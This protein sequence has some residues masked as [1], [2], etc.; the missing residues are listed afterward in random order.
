MQRRRSRFATGASRCAR[1]P[2]DL[3]HTHTMSVANDRLKIVAEEWQ[4]FKR[5]I[6]ALFVAMCGKA[7]LHSD[8]TE[9]RSLAEAPLPHEK[10]VCA[11]SSRV[12]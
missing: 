2:V 6:A 10:V 3:D 12:R 11:F 9:R 5:C 7:G 8:I 1:L 4:R